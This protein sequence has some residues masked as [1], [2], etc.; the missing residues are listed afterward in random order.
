M[1]KRIAIIALLT[2]SLVSAKTYSFTVSEPAQAGNTQLKAGE[3]SLKVDGEQVVL[4]D[5]G[6]HRID[7][8]AK[9]EAAD[10]KFDKTAICISSADGAKRI[11]WI[12]LGGSKMRVV[13]Q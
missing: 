3:Y 13:F 8:T 2:I 9:I 4:T 6:G 7:V 5:N 1:F 12:H 10:Q 11:E